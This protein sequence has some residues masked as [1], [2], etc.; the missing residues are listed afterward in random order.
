MRIL[1]EEKPKKTTFGLIVGTHQLHVRL[2]PNVRSVRQGTPIIP[3]KLG[4]EVAHNGERPEAIVGGG[5]D[6][7]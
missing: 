2:S 7:D 6:G 1:I 4:W 3:G 5:F